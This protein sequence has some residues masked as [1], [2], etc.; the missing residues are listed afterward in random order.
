[1]ASERLDRV[2]VYMV[3]DDARVVGEQKSKSEDVWSDRFASAIIGDFGDSVVSSLKASVRRR[4]REGDAESITSARSIDS[5]WVSWRLGDHKFVVGPVLDA[6]DA[7]KV[8][9]E[10]QRIDNNFGMQK[11]LLTRPSFCPI[12]NLSSED[13]ADLPQAILERG[14]ATGKF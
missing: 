9:L 7:D 2:L 8:C 13:R 10:K 3:K 4:H 1:M 11:C 14:I 6:S 12:T 5:V